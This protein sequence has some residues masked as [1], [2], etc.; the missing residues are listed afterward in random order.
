MIETTIETQSSGLFNFDPKKG[1]RYAYDYVK[2]TE[3]LNTAK[4]DG[5]PNAAMAIMR[6][7]GTS[8]MFFFAYFVLGLDYLNHP[9]ILNRIREVQHNHNMTMDL[10]PR[11]HFKSTIITYI[12]P[13]FTVLSNPEARFAIFSHSR[14][15]ARSFLGKIKTTLEI[16]QFLKT[17]WPDVF[18]ENPEDDS[19]RWSALDGLIVK[20][21]GTYQ[22]GTFE[23]WGVTERMPTGK[24]FTH[25][26]YDDLVTDDYCKT[27]DQREKV[28][29]GY[30]LSL[31]LCSEH[32]EEMIVGTHYHY[33]DL[34]VHI[35]SLSDH[36]VRFYP[37]ELMTNG[38]YNG[39][40]IYL[41]AEELKKK[42]R[43]MGSHVYNTQMLLNP[44]P[45]ADRKFKVEWLQY[46]N[47]IPEPMNIYILCDPANSKRS[48]RA[49]KDY[50]VFWVVGI[51]A[52]GNRYLLDGVRDRLNLSERWKALWYLYKK[53]GMHRIKKVGYERYGKDSDSQYF[54]E[55]AKGQGVRIPIEELGGTTSKPERI[56]WLLP[57]FEAME[58]HLPTAIYYTDTEKNRHNLI[59]ELITEEYYA[60][61][62][63]RM[64][65]K[66]DDM[67][68]C[69]ARIEDP[70]L[71]AE[72]PFS[73]MPEAHV[74]KEYNPFETTKSG[75]AS[76]RAW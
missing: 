51:A 61:D 47:R 15:Q 37:A 1:A 48:D 45:E 57:R 4:M 19:P 11:G 49:D 2:I 50:T 67:L 17:V 26:I 75:G 76:W 65:G 5:D 42:R 44:V 52:N 63:E 62:G 70:K 71:K 46:Y 3:D 32:D 33:D 69:L 7:M 25:R 8:D 64:Y 43:Q 14:I 22:E 58:W 13:I 68:D 74:K 34:Y 29:K 55:Q 16:N 24:H 6:E 20:R 9:W 54:Q 28:K 27:P 40:G 59:Q 38:V 39:E 60:W 56:A 10:W 53:W 21:K 31:N 73:R 72:A 12:H 66:H 36:E 18:Y 35:K 30:Q 41:S 23:S